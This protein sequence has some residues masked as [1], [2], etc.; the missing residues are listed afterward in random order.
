MRPKL[1]QIEYVSVL[2]Q[3]LHAEFSEFFVQNS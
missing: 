3:K 1:F 2:Y